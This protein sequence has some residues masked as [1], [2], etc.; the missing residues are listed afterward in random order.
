M[1]SRY[2]AIYERELD[3]LLFGGVLP[4]NYERSTIPPPEVEPPKPTTI[5]RYLVLDTKTNKL[6]LKSVPNTESIDS[7]V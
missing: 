7:E 5:K 2:D 1:K 6:S 3:L 4:S